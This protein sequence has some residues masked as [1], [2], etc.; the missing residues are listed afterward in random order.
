MAWVRSFPVIGFRALGH[1]PKADDSSQ[2]SLGI[3]Q[4][5]SIISTEDRQHIGRPHIGDR[6]FSLGSSPLSSPP[7]APRAPHQIPVVYMPIA[8]A[9]Y[10]HPASSHLDLTLTTESTP[11]NQ[12]TT[13]DIVFAFSNLVHAVSSV[14]LRKVSRMMIKAFEER[15]INLCRPGTR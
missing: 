1:L 2:A 6:C 8:R 9:F 15:C 10:V 7:S 3:I 12:A 11:T 13:F 4:A 14:F 5:Q